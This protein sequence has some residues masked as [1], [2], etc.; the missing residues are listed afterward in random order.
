M[1]ALNEALQKAGEETRF[2]RVR[3]SP[4][5]AVFVLLT[6]KANMGLIIPRLSNV[7]IQAVKI[8]DQ[9]IV[10]VEILEYWQRLN[11]HKMSLER[12]LDKDIWNC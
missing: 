6:E 8:M 7:L 1:L 3:Y 9:A 5:K 12:Y 11:V 10:G 4:S 2:C